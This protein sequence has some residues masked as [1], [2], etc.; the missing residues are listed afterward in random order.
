MIAELDPPALL[1]LGGILLGAGFGALAQ[2]SHFCIMGSLADLVLFGSARRLRSWLLAIAVAILGTQLAAWLGLVPLAES[3]HLAPA[4]AL[5]PAILGG[6]AFGFGMV[7]AGGCASRSLV[8]AA[9]GSLEALV[10]L[11]VMAVASWA[12]QLGPLAPLHRAL[13]EA[14]TLE[15]ARPQA[16]SEPLAALSGTGSEEA[17][18]LL[19]LLLGL[20]LFLFCFADPRFRGRR[21]E[22]A[23]GFGLGLL[24]VAGWLWT[25]W[26]AR[27]PFE[28]AGP[29]SLSYVGPVAESLLYVVTGES[30]APF[31]PALVL[32]TVAGAAA[33][34]LARGGFRLRAGEG[35][36]GL[37]RP[38][39]GAVLMGVGGAMAMGCTIGQGLSGVSTLGASS[40]VA[41]L[42]IVAGGTWALRWLETGSLLLG[43]E[44]RRRAPARPAEP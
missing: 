26:L 25:G 6:L 24:V 32:G 5:G 34:A 44:R 19:G 7:L 22:V 18:L 41:T 11:L 39:L 43:L 31:G 14:T 8:R 13:R 30:R 2:A 10:V 42:A 21:A 4:I 17:R 40:L 23:T 27:D 3:R 16:L 35:A 33:V 12:A 1:V 28:P 15:L 37:G 29:Q 36:A 9:S 38:L 20:A